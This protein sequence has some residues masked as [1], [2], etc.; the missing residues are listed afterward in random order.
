MRAAAP[1]AAAPGAFRPKFL[2]PRKSLHPL[3]RAT[4][5]KV[6]F[7]SSSPQPEAAHPIAG[8]SPGWS[9]LRRSRRVRRL[10]LADVAPLGL[11]VVDAKW[12]RR[13]RR[14]A[15]RNDERSLGRP[16]LPFRGS[17][18]DPVRSRTRRKCHRPCKPSSG[19]DVPPVVGSA[20][21]K[22]EGRSDRQCRSGCCETYVKRSGGARV[23]NIAG[24]SGCGSATRPYS[25]EESSHD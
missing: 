15:R 6:G 1:H 24:P 5:A 17:W 18:P 25:S 2:P 7:Y 22:I 11:G 14:R 9:R 12:R 23:R 13:R 21:W 10:W 20:W 19:T 8:R 4:S 3:P 16:Q